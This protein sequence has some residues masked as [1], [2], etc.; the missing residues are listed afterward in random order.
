MPKTSSLKAGV[1]PGHASQPSN[2]VPGNAHPAMCDSNRKNHVNSRI[3][4]EDSIRRR[5]SKYL[6]YR[7]LSF[8]CS[9]TLD[10]EPSWT[11]S[12]VATP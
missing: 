7:N 10:L 2:I 6:S 1:S 3:R 9:D 4:S 5:C 12:V 8:R 11:R